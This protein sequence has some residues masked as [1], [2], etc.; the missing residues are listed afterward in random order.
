MET[1]IEL[2]GLFSASKSGSRLSMLVSGTWHF[3]AQ[4]EMSV[5]SA[6]SGSKDDVARGCTATAGLAPF[7]LAVQV[8][9]GV[10]RVFVDVEWSGYICVEILYYYA[11]SLYHAA[12][13]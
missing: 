13:L 10:R 8:V 4:T 2:R 7:W 12:I 9:A 5:V 11:T 6:R 1:R 3:V